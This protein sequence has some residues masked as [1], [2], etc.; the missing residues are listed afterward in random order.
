MNLRKTFFIL[1][2]LFTL[3][4]VFCG[5]FAI[6][7][8]AGPTSIDSLYQ[9]AIAICFA[10]F[11]D[12]A[13]GRVARLTKTQSALGME[14]DSLA[15]VISFGAAPALLVY[16]WGL[17]SFGLAGV[18]IAFVYCGAGALR[19]ARFNV[20]SMQ[21][22]SSK[23]GKY[24][25]GLPVP[26]AASVLVSIVVL[27]HQLGGSFVRAGQASVAVLV[28]VLSYLM[29]S[30]IRF[31]SFKDLR[32]TKRTIAGGIIILAFTGLAL[33]SK[34]HSAFIFVALMAMYLALG[35]LEEIIFYRRRREEEL[36]AKQPMELEADGGARS[37]EEVLAELG[38][39]DSEPNELEPPTTRTTTQR[40][41]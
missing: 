3:S 36:A 37:D 31:R 33:M 17:T 39:Y 23:P 35:L 13:D 41:T 14:L 21:K 32:F 5:F 10:F 2:N 30:R 12:L 29:V 22:D 8:C 38:A 40:Q 18:F 25:I 20:L 26:V 9:A 24:I 15:D 16:K 7:L 6:T 11:F 27:N 28:L 19:L 1:P 4:S 34:M